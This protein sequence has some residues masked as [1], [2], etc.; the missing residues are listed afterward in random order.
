M[1]S[2]IILHYKNVQDT[3]ECIESIKLLSN[4]EK[5]SIIIVDNNSG[6]GKEL[7]KLKKFTSDII[8]SDKNLGFAKGNNL[9]CRYAIDKYHPD[10]LA[11]INNDTIINQKN[12]ISIIER[13]YKKFNFD[14][15]GP[16]IITDG[17][18]SVNPFP[19]YND[20]NEVQKQI[21][22]SK[23][24]IRIYS[25]VILR[26][27]LKVYTNIKSLFISKKHCIN[28]QH[29]SEDVALHGCS[30]VFSKKYYEKYYDVFYPGTFLYHEEEF[31]EYRR[32]KDCLKTIYDPELEIFHKEGASLD[33]KFEG[34]EY[35]KLVFRH[36]QI[37]ESLSLLEKIMI[38]NEKI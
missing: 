36:K 12:F 37:V 22:K 17:G 24:L 4:Q 25:N 15:L 27:L 2:F 32:K 1:I 19:V 29:L 31:L 14:I 28:G 20:L 11:V 6:N 3:L 16:K 10:F 8:V 34:L 5:I 9:G 7:K 21:R 23:K 30:L 33:I 35:K 26:E 13:D 18:E 38:N